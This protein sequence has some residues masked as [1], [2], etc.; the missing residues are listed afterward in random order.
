[1]TQP[2]K[3]PSQSNPDSKPGQPFDLEGIPIP[4]MSLDDLAPQSDVSETPKREKTAEDVTEVAF[5]DFSFEELLK[6]LGETRSSQPVP[7]QKEERPAA[8][9]E[10]EVRLDMLDGLDLPEMQLSESDGP[11]ESSGNAPVA[12]SVSIPEP[13]PSFNPAESVPIPE[14]SLDDLVEPTARSVSESQ[15]AAE[16]V[17]SERESDL[18]QFDGLDLLDVHLTEEPQPGPSA[19]RAKPA[20]EPVSVSVESVP[21][22]EMSLDDLELPQ[23][24]PVPVSAPPKPVQPE[25]PVSTLDLS[26][27][28]GVELPEARVFSMG[29][30]PVALTDSAPKKQPDTPK[31]VS[32]PSE[33]RISILEPTIDDLVPGVEIVSDALPVPLKMES[34]EGEEE[35]Q[36]PE[37]IIEAQHS[38][39][40]VSPLRRKSV[41]NPAQA[42]AAFKSLFAQ[43]DVPGILSLYEAQVDSRVKRQ[44]IDWLVKHVET[45][46]VTPLL[47]VGSVETDEEMFRYMIREI[48]KLDR[49]KVCKLI[50]VETCPRPL[51][52]VAVMVLSELGLRSALPKLQKCVEVGDAVVRSVA[53]HGIGRSGEAAEPLI[54]F[55]LKT[56]E[57]ETDKNV[58]VAAAKALQAMN[59]RKAYEAFEEKAH[60]V[61][62]DPVVA[63]VLEELRAKFDPT[64]E[65]RTRL[66]GPRAASKTP[67]KGSSKASGKG[68]ADQGKA[69]KLAVA[70]LVILAAIYFL[71]QQLLKK[72]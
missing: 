72:G 43:S 64:G 21:I 44:A 32:V 54:P 48:L 70:V 28:D 67:E 30:S 10:V 12:P 27:L 50:E 3:T 6:D 5:P 34:E 38:S 53:L 57:Q 65:N 52:Q 55:L 17:V 66:G 36:E 20:P 69:A 8:A 56:V 51:L 49:G 11:P 42:V 59:S 13:I 2:E 18:S 62:L 35:P 1:M 61:S 16:P 15:S 37:V 33:E 45:L 4:E 19:V 7:P 25:E 39:A 14:F 24:Q 29:D 63:H 46:G 68:N 47:S 41:L 26:G 9:P 71:Y 23:E 22:P 31:P 58:R 60:E 40:E